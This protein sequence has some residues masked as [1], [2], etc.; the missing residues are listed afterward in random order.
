M[1]WTR[2]GAN[3]HPHVVVRPILTTTSQWEGWSGVLGGGRWQNLMY[4]RTDKGLRKPKS[5]F[6][7][8]TMIGEE[9]VAWR[10]WRTAHG[11]TD[12]GPPS[13]STPPLAL[14]DAKPPGAVGDDERE[15]GLPVSAGPAESTTV[16]G[17]VMPVT[18]RAGDLGANNQV[19]KV[20]SF[21]E[22]VSMPAR[23]TDSSAGYVL[24]ATQGHMVQP[25]ET[26]PIPTGVGVEFAQ[27]HVGMICS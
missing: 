15:E 27:G 3:G 22:K 9:A 18:S 4:H 12:D 17:V 7:A 11:Y 6:G 24:S 14:E 25:G 16:E 20:R 19:V 1:V 2:V 5:W 10:K 21:R 26:C 23:G 13:A 8:R